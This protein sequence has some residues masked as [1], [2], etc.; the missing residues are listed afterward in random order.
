MLSGVG[1]DGRVWLRQLRAPG[2][3]EDPLPFL[4][5]SMVCSTI[6]LLTLLVSSTFSGARGLAWS[7]VLSFPATTTNWHQFPGLRSD[8]RKKGSPGP[9]LCPENL[10]N[11]LLDIR[12][13]LLFR[14]I[15]TTFSSLPR[16]SLLTPFGEM[17]GLS[18]PP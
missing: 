4:F 7:P 5:L 3:S 18:E 2:L 12:F 9:C 16:S 17:C 14:R 1:E 15:K 6:A 13:T 8:S 11:I 10:C